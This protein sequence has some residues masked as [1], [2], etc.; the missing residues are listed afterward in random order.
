M[1][2]KRY[3]A[4]DEGQVTEA[5]RLQEKLKQQRIDDLNWVMSDL[6]GRRFMSELLSRTGPLTLSFTGNSQTFF[7]E[8]QRNVGLMYIADLEEH[9]QE[10]NFQMMR[11]NKEREEKQNA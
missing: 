6:R 8:G 5:E 1:S 11:E 10:Q 4:S 3:N 9:C 7:N 2:K